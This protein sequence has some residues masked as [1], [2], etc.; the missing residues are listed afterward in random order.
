MKIDH[1]EHFKVIIF[2]LVSLASTEQKWS[3]PLKCFYKNYEYPNKKATMKITIYLRVIFLKKYIHD[4]PCGSEF[5]STK[6]IFL[7]RH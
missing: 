5:S 4:K 2:Y 1:F 3:G 7:H 6:S